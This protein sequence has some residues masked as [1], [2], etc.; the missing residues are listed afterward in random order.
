MRTKEE[1]L[2]YL[3][4]NG[5]SSNAITKITGFLIGKGLK[6]EQEQI[7]Y[8][9]GHATWDEFY[10]WYKNES[11]SVKPPIYHV[12]AALFKAKDEAKDP[13]DKVCINTVINFLVGKYVVDTTIFNKSCEKENK[14][15]S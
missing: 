9:R 12:F 14:S 13:Y 1:I 6:S 8:K 3:K 2:T 10:A 4:E 15:R 7:L 11:P 5:H